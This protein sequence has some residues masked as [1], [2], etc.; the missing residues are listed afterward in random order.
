M[1]TG[2]T[3]HVARERGEGLT[4]VQLPLGQFH[5]SYARLTVIDAAGKRAWSNPFWLD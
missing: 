3:Y 2:A 1:L 4:K 5:R